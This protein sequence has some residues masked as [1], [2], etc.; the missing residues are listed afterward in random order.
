[1]A[2]HVPRDLPD[3]A[4]FGAPLEVVLVAADQP[5]RYSPVYVGIVTTDID[6][7]FLLPEVGDPA[8]L[9]AAIEHAQWHPGI[10]VL[11][12]GLLPSANEDLVTA[13]EA[14]LAARPRITPWK[15]LSALVGPHPDHR[16]CSYCRAGG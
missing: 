12:V 7:V 3:P 13:V 4:A 5:G 8:H 6:A 1:M 16:C 15:R 10:R 2:L 14:L 9:A 11:S